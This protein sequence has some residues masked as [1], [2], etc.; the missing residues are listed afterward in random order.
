MARK[1][2]VYTVTD[3]NRDK[4]K[5]FVITEMAP[6]VGHAWATRALFGIM[7][8][9]I[10]MP[11]DWLDTG[12]AGLANAG[13]KALGNLRPEI[14]V[15]LMGE[16]LTCVQV[17]PN[18]DDPARLRADWENDVEE[19]STIFKLQFEVFKLHTGFSMPAAK[20]TSASAAGPETPG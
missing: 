9:G 7:N 19:A 3:D 15:P 11:A 20:S 10:D 1:T 8:G 13:F 18:A 16:L 6:R 12:M 4:G 17:R 2:L 14:G 5:V